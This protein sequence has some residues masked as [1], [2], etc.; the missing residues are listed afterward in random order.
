MNMTTSLDSIP[1]KTS[2]KNNDIVMDDSDDPMVKDIL[3]E[4]QQE[5]EINTQKPLSLNEKQNY[6]INFN[7]QK[8]DKIDTE[9]YCNNGNCNIPNKNS[10]SNTKNSYYNELYIK[11]SL[12]I[13]IIV[14]LI[15]SPIFIPS[16]FEKLPQS[17]IPI[18]EN[19][20][21]YIKIFIL[22]IS[23]YILFFYNL[24]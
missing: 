24:I 16:I 14:F 22:F 9:K 6:N 7:S 2:N 15:F 1:L 5:L 4:F 21:L 17:F 23:I 3:N 12:I 13:I 20:E 8:E 10:N 19:Y 11:K 18:I